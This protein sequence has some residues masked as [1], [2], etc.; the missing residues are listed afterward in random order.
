MKRNEFLRLSG[1]LAL[2]GLTSKSAFA[3]LTDDEGT[4][5]L[6]YFG[7]QLYSLRADLPADPKGVLVMKEPKAC[8]GE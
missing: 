8:F 3:S 1:G 6:K 5:K 2:A 4:K 7:L